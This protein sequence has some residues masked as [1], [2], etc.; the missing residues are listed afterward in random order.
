MIE[1]ARASD[2]PA[3]RRLLEASGLPHGDVT[4]TLLAHYLV[5]GHAEALTGVV[6][7]EP[8]G[9]VGLL[10]SL[11]VATAQ[12]GHG[13]GVA[14]TAALEA[15]ARGLGITDL[16]LLTTTAERFFGTLGYRVILRS[17]APTPLQATTEFREL[18]SSSAVCMVKTLE[19]KEQTMAGNR[20]TRPASDE[21]APYYARYIEQVPDGPIL[22]LL[23]RQVNDTGALLGKLG[24]RDADFRYA[25]GK[26]SVKEVVG[27]VADTE[28]IFAYR[29]LCFA[30]ADATALPGFDENAYVA[31]AKF[32]GRTLADLVAE[33]RLVRAATVAFFAGLDAE[34]VTRRGTANNNP[35]SVRALAFIIAGHERHHAKILA[36]RYLPG[37][38]KR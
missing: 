20:I 9:S 25:E 23:E 21:Y 13:L 27:H 37:L 30:R 22:E 10:R 19:P 34:E 36:E 15:H 5:A 32:A 17:T 12:R 14:L 1:A 7:L 16:Y 29:A 18:C 35:Y 26:W 11:A 24:G 38:P 2:L 4:A 33:F 6:G 8:L 3:V 31:R 28:R